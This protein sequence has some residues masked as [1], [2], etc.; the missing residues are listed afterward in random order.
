MLHCNYGDGE[1]GD[2]INRL[3]SLF[4]H[5]TNLILP[6]GAW[7]DLDD[8]HSCL[9]PEKNSMRIMVLLIKYQ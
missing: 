2:N 3:Y 7:S 9:R 6:G 4:C 1:N 8:D 5:Q